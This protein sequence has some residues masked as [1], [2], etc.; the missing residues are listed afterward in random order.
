MRLLHKGAPLFPCALSALQPRPARASARRDESRRARRRLQGEPPPRQAQGLGRGAQSRAGRRGHACHTGRQHSTAAGPRAAPGGQGTIAARPRRGR[1]GGGGGQREDACR[2]ARARCPGGASGAGAP[3]WR[4][5]GQQRILWACSLAGGQGGGG[6]TQGGR[7]EQGAEG[8][9]GCGG[10]LGGLRSV[11]RAPVYPEPRPL[12]NACSLP[13][14]SSSLPNACSLL[15]TLSSL[16]N[17]CSLPRTSSSL[18][19]ISY[20]R[21]PSPPCLTPVIC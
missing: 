20:C 21:T 5:P 8:G 18:P 11:C 19:V 3:G 16:P 12:P 15:C 6:G 1:G 4:G 13:R 2:R 17:A 9:V 14:T 7:K 10:A